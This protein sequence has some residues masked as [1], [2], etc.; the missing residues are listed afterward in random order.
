MDKNK[1][2]SG[3][4]ARKL[5]C[6][7]FIIASYVFTSLSWY[8]GYSD[9]VRQLSSISRYMAW[10][11][12]AIILFSHLSGKFSKASPSPSSVKKK[13]SVNKLF[14]RLKQKISKTDVDSLLDQEEDGSSPA[15]D[16]SSLGGAFSVDT[17]T[18]TKKN[19]RFIRL[20]MLYVI[21]QIFLLI[22]FVSSSVMSYSLPTKG[23][24]VNY[25]FLHIAIFAT[26][27]IASFSLQK[28]IETKDGGDGDKT[29]LSYFAVFG[30][31]CTISA[32]FVA[33][34]VVLSIECVYMLLWVY[35]IVSIYL[36]AMT[37]FRIITSII[38]NDELMDF[39]YTIYVPFITKYQKENIFG[40][41]EKT[42]GLSLKS[43]WSIKY[44]AELIPGAVIGVVFLLLLSTC[45]Y[46]VEPYQQAALYRFGA[47]S[48]N[49]IK[50]NG[51]HLKLPWPID[52]VEIYDVDRVKSMTI[53]YE[54]TVATDY[55]WTRSHGGEE[56]K[57][58]M[59]NGNELVS[60]N[61][62]LAYRIDSLHSFVTKATEP[63]S[64]ISAK[65][66]EIIMNKTI[67]T[68]IDRFLS[69]DRSSLS[70]QI[71]KDLNDFC[72]NESL[73]ITINEVII[74]S[75][76]PPIEIAQVYQEV[77]SAEIKKETIITNA[78]ASALQAISAAEKNAKTEIIDAGSNQSHK[79]ATAISDM[80][81]FNA[82]FEAYKVSPEAFRL[83]KYLT[84]YE[85]IISDNKIYV[86]TPNVSSD[87]SRYII[88]SSSGK[89]D[90]T[91]IENLED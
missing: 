33:L 7:F 81:V 23:S 65:A 6:A 48:E 59:G 73:G 36:V 71:K 39:D 88:N 89:E 1:P 32:L 35:R 64:I 80:A 69:V 3:S 63:E 76:H 60:V 82:A 66:Y 4:A 86:F 44:I 42:T 14:K 47:F 26:F 19:K 40:V 87:L 30:A 11:T 70:E 8:G 13:K 20:K 38:K 46:K 10:A 50:S 53:G 31:L 56:Y 72:S 21:V 90:M 25:S 49:S 54:E 15:D 37:A 28:W 5:P 27:A 77:V 79:T 17:D 43:L 58:L 74:E 52:K 84:T 62:K 57:L 85:K 41:L 9:V 78:Q 12:A 83:N 75:V 29:S 34:Q 18:S 45:M 16:D 2:E 91:I 51:V 68:T 55:L 67:T 61:I 22:V 24:N